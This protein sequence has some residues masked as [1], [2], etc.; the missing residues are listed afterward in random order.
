MPSAWFGDT[1][2]KALEIYIQVHRDLTPG[3]RL[4][5]IFALCDFQQVLQIANVRGMHP[6]RANERYS[7]AWPLDASAG[8]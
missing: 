6:T 4:T 2:P 7:Y 1:D 3:Q 8:S 5:R